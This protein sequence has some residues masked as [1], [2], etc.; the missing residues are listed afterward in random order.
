MGNTLQPLLIIVLIALLLVR[1][2][3]GRVLRPDKLLTVPIILIAIGVVSVL[4]KLHGFSL[5]GADALVLLGDLVIC[6]G[7]GL[8]RGF[9]VVLYRVDGQLWQRYGAVTVAL[10]LLTIVARVGL[11]LL[12]KSLGADPLVTSGLLLVLFGLTLVVQNVVVGR[13]AQ[14]I[15]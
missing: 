7:L 10:W 13:R 14:T 8:W 2:T 1:R 9:S 12:G 3:R 5:S 15:G 4:P 6:L 11:G